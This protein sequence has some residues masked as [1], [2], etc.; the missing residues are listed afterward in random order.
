MERKDRGI[1][2]AGLEANLAGLSLAHHTSEA[3]RQSVERYAVNQGD[4]TCYPFAQDVQ[5]QASGLRKVTARC[6]GT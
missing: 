3:L 1:M 5:C 2:G 4:K 6:P